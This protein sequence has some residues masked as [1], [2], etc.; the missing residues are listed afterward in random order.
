MFVLSM[1]SFYTYFIRPL[2]GV[3]WS[4]GCPGLVGIHYDTNMER[5]TITRQH[6]TAKPKPNCRLLFSF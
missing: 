4:S 1:S 6:M 5:L 2:F 3:V